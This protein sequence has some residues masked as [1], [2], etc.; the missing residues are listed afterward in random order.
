MAAKNKPVDE[1]D[2]TGLGI[3]PST[4]GWA[5]AGQEITDIAEAPAR[6]AGE[7]VVDEGDAHERVLAFLD[8]LKVI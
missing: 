7:V 8:D 3:D 2:L 4:V 5:G 6:E 1:V